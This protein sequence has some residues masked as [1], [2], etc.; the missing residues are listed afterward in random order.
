[1]YTQWCPLHAS[2]KNS[3]GREGWLRPKLVPF[4]PKRE[5]EGGGGAEDLQ[6]VKNENDKLWQKYSTRRGGGVLT[7][8]TSRSANKSTALAKQSVI[9]VCIQTG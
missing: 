2:T 6:M 5:R 1:M 3:K 7:L 4:P 9:Y 8:I